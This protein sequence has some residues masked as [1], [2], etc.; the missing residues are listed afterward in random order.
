MLVAF[1]SLWLLWDS[2]ES[3]SAAD[4]NEDKSF[5]FGIPALCVA[6]SFY[7]KQRTWK[8]EPE[9][10]F[11]APLRSPLDACWQSCSDPG[12]TPEG[13]ASGEHRAPESGAF[14]GIMN[15]KW[16]A[17]C[18]SAFLRYF[19]R[20]SMHKLPRVLRMCDDAAGLNCGLMRGNVEISR[21]SS[22]TSRRVRPHSAG[23]AR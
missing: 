13:P 16:D 15:E 20:N 18:H 2:A 1:V 3:D 8:T 23:R 17:P 10:T 21:N 4:I 7:G 14:K 12:V 6:Y 19:C 22:L 5:S 11:F 9:R